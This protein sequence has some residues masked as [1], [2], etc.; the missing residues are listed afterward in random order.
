MDVG[1]DNAKHLLGEYR[2]F[3]EDDIISILGAQPG[4]HPISF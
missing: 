1:V 3:S 4:H 2:P